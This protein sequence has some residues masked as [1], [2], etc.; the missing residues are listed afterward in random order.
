MRVCMRVCTYILQIYRFIY[1]YKNVSVFI[2]LTHFASVS[3]CHNVCVI[4]ARVCMF[5]R[6]AQAAKRAVERLI[7]LKQRVKTASEGNRDVVGLNLSCS[8]LVFEEN[9]CVCAGV[10]VFWSCLNRK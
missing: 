5:Q 4:L 8:T 9:K 7:W 3:F 2:Y 6:V 1:R 10:F